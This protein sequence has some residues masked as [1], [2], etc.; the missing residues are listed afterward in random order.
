MFFQQEHRE[1]S[2]PST[3][4]GNGSQVNVALSVHH[5]PQNQLSSISPC[6]KEDLWHLPGQLRESNPLTRKTYHSINNIQPSRCSR[7]YKKHKRL[8][9]TV[10]F[11]CVCPFSRNKPVSLGQGGC[12]PLAPLGSEGVF[13][14][15]A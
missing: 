6:S 5:S 13:T 11:S 2:P 7:H 3:M 9:V 1:N 15:P 4:Q 8:P 14:A 10:C 12:W